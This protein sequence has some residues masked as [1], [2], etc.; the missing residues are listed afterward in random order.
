M[1]YRLALAAVLALGGALPAAAGYQE[2]LIA[3]ETGDYTTAYREFHALARQGQPNAQFALAQMYRFG[4]GVP[5]DD[6]EAFT[7]FRRAGKGGHAEARTVLG[8]LYAYG[9]GTGQDNFQAY[10]WFSLAVTQANPA[11]AANRDKIAR[12]LSAAQRAEVDRLVADARRDAETLSRD[13]TSASTATLPAEPKTV[14][15]TETQNGSAAALATAPG[16]FW[17]QLGAFLTAENAPAVWWRLRAAQLDLLG[18]VRH[19]IQRADNGGRVFHLLQVGP[20][21]GA[22]AAKALCAALAARGVDCLV[23]KP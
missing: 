14:E 20:L 4:A 6:V 15:A 18:G 16:S 9:V 23:V 5:Q 3:F 1:I 19:R 12:L 17:V 7:W 2:G 21:D 11:V 13:L 8:F 10:F 22:E